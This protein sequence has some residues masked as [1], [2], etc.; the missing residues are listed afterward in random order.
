MG[1][2]L[3]RPEVPQGSTYYSN[4]NE[5]L[6]DCDTGDVVLWSGNSGESLVVRLFGME[7]LWS[8]IGVVHIHNGRKCLFES[9]RGYHPYDIRSRTYKDGARLSD[10]REKLETYKGF[11]VALKKLGRVHDRDYFNAR[12]RDAVEKLADVPYAQDTFELMSSVYRNNVEDSRGDSCIEI[13]AKYGME[14]QI[15]D[16]SR[17]AN[18]YKLR[19]FT[20]EWQDLPYR[21]NNSPRWA[22]ERYLLLRS[23]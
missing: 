21:D 22:S 20:S 23:R 15:L 18:N 2:T 9:V 6:N 14:T 17:R 10:L 16:T 8:H 19:D 5:F 12:A 1:S 3:C 4:I 7:D 11:F 13:I